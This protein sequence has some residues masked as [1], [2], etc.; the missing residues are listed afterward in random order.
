MA[1]LAAAV[2]DN[3]DAVGAMLGHGVVFHKP[4]LFSEMAAAGVK[5]GALP[6]EIAVDITAAQESA[7]RMSFLT[8]GMARYGREE[9][10]VTCP[11]KGKGA[12][13]FVF[14][15]TRWLLTDRDKQLATGETIGRTA[16]EKIR[17]ER[18]P[19]PTGRGGPVIRLALA[20]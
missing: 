17:I 10:Y 14:D 12:L 19:N 18:V 13:G 15:L 4:A 6:P 16:E 1:L 2:I 20:R 5:T 11:I 9:L 7:K 3:V 8:H